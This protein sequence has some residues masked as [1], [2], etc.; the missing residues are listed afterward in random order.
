MSARFTPQRPDGRARWR[1]AFDYIAAG[2]ASGSLQTG[3]VIE[4]ETLARE[5]DTEFPGSA[6]YMAMTRAAAE[7]QRERQKSL[8]SERGVGYRI[9]QGTAMIDQGRGHQNKAQRSVGK[10]IA[11]ANAVDENDLDTASDV[12]MVRGVRRGFALLGAVLAQHAEHLNEHDRQIEKL[13]EA[14][15]ET[16]R[17]HRATDDE[18]AD[19]RRRLDRLEAEQS[20][21]S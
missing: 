1:V 3:S 17:H 19:L 11:V 13:N 2:L 15:N 14:T 10:A 16:R 8:L 4:H 21:E 5:M 9:I 20:A 6:Y 12:S 7:L 18:V